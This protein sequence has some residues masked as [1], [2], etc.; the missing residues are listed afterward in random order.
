MC[1][2]DQCVLTMRIDMAAYTP[3]P[4]YHMQL[5]TNLFGT[6]LPTESL[7]EGVYEVSFEVPRQQS[8]VYSLDGKLRAYLAE[9][10]A[11]QQTARAL[12]H[13]NKRLMLS[14]ARRQADNAS[15]PIA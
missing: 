11:L 9:N 12:V 6:V 7:V 3:A 8:L 2:T 1:G 14:L 5:W 15:A 4:W 13:S 10:A